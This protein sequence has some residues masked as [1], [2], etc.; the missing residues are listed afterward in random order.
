LWQG[1]RREREGKEKRKE[2]EGSWEV[3]V[4]DKKEKG[5]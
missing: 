4:G 2:G 5:E 3:Q 1:R